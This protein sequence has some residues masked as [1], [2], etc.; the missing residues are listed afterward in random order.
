MTINTHK[1]PAQSCPG[2]G[3]ELS[4]A[5]ASHDASPTVGAVTVCIECGAVLEFGEGLL[6]RAL[7]PEQVDALPEYLRDAVKE[8]VKR[9]KAV[10]YTATLRKMALAAV[11][12]I[13]R[14][15]PDGLAF[16]LP[17]EDMMF[18]A[19][20]TDEAIGMLAANRRSRAFLRALDAAT[21]KAATAFQ[22]AQV[23]RAM[24]LPSTVWPESYVAE[25]LARGTSFITGRK[26]GQA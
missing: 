13:E 10:S 12:W 11:D 25:L 3:V 4:A 1:V 21:S 16:V 23:I 20:L 5:S 18:I 6:L 22:A 15:K 8:N 17:P 14:N 2:C 19:P 9:Q 24:G 7:T 26:A